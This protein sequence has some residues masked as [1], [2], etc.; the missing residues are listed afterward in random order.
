MK[1]NCLDIGLIQAFLDGETA[2]DETIRVSGHIAKCNACALM[3]AEA[4]DESAIVFPALER[5]FN[6]LVPTH[7]LWNKINES[8]ATERDHAPFWQKAWAYLTLALASPSIAAAAGLILVVGVVSAIWMS[9]VPVSND[10]AVN[11]NPTKTSSPVENITTNA[12]LNPPTEFQI[13]SVSQPL[14][15]KFERAVYHADN[16][17]GPAQSTSGKGQAASN[18]YAS[19]EESYIKTISSLSRSANEQKDAVMRPSER[20][21]FESDMAVVDDAISKMSKQIKQDPK[22]DSAR[23]V[24][25]TSYQNKIDLLN[26]VSQRQE[27]MAS[28]K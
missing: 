25:Y 16:R 4:E 26:S 23:R 10:A 17:R 8:I 11:A 18:S 7:R 13:T 9:R 3:L 14:A 15:A 2:H 21:A 20:V 22:N 5:E 12:Q 1:N 27:L 28:V 24:L 19:D 6:T